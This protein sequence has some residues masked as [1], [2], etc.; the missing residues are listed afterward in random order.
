MAPLE[1][2]PKGPPR[3]LTSLLPLNLTSQNELLQPLFEDAIDR[4][5]HNPNQPAHGARPERNVRSPPS[6]LQIQRQADYALLPPHQFELGA[7]KYGGYFRVVALG[8]V[9]RAE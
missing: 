5:S 1:A 7:G 3:T 2:R 6:P 9:L 4:T 8:D